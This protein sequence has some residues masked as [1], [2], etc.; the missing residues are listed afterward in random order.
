MPED[1]IQDSLSRALRR[2]A[3]EDQAL[4]ARPE[5]EAAVIA[6][7]RKRRESTRSGWWLA[8]AAA[9]V[10][11]VASALWWTGRSPEPVAQAPANGPTEVG[12]DYFPLRAGPVLDAGEFGR[13]IRVPVS[14]ATMVRF[15]L[16]ATAIP[17]GDLV[18]ADVLL[19]MDGTARAVRFV[20]STE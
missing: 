10:M 6:A 9:L 2:M 11:G 5:T 15:G 3:A 1:E 18:N 16:T 20:R 7:F 8:A 19:G 4:E 17:G 12:T 14:R 13:V